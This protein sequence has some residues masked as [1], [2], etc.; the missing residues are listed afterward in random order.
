MTDITQAVERC[1]KF[2]VLAAL[3]HQR[4]RRVLLSGPVAA[5]IRVRE[6]VES[7]RFDVYDVDELTQ[8]SGT[9]DLSQGLGIRRIAEN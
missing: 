9:N 2:D 3:G 1:T 8:G 7:N 5:H 6:V 4:E